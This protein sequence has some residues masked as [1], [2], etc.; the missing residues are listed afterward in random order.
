MAKLV[1]ER[2]CIVLKEFESHVRMAERSKAPDS[3]GITLGSL[4]RMW[5]FW[6]TNV[7]VGSNPTSDK[8]FF[9]LLKNC[10]SLLGLDFSAFEV[11]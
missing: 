7:G 6:S 11:N 1:T 3:R 2:K 9:R 10:L 8:Y 5:V 4:M